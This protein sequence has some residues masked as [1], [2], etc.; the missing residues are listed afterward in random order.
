MYPKLS[1]LINDLL[2]TDVNLPI[3]SYG[4]FVALAFLVAGYIFY[5]ELKRKEKAGLL[6]PQKRKVIKGKPASTSDLLVSGIVAFFIGFKLVDIFFNYSFFANNPQEYLFSWQGNWLGG[7]LIGGGSVFYTWWKKNKAKL[8]KPQEVEEIVHPYELTGTIILVAAISGIIG[9][10]IFHQFENWDEFLADPMGSL[11]SFSGLTFYGGLIVATFV[12]VWF[13][14]KN[15]IPWPR[16]GDAIAPSLMIAYGIGRIGCQVSGDGDWGIVN[17][18]PKPDWLSWIPDWLWAYDYPHNVL[19]EGIPI[20]GCTG[21]YCFK[22]AETV[23]PTPIYETLTCL[24]FFGILWSFR[25]RFRVPGMLFAIY[26]ILNGIERFF[27]EKIRV[28][29]TYEVAGF[30]ITQAEI[31]SVVLVLLGVAGIWYF[32]HRHKKMH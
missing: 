27:I 23:Y 4:F 13:A 25:K 30:E 2:G 9:A 16:L 28:N 18:A 31:I 7:I 20:E 17:T 1:D 3:Q 5:L 29:N 32:I 15:K 21:D 6:M 26:L 10:K 8:D 11:F 24:L 22:L 19:R 14:G 12:V